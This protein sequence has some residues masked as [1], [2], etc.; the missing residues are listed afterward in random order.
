MKATRRLLLTGIVLGS[1]LTLAPLFGI[2]GTVVGMIRAFRVLGSSGI[3]D[4]QALSQS[5]GT[6]LLSTATGIFLCP[7]GVII[8]SLSL[9]FFY[10]LRRSNPPALPPHAPLDR[11]QCEV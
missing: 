6:T 1:L 11:N 3:A 8:L 5:M 2:L 10:Q 4:P 9:V 7:F